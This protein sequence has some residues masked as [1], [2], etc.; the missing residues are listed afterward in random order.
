[1]KNDMHADTVILSKKLVAMDARGWDGPGYVAIKG[2][3]IVGVGH[4]DEMQAMVGPATVVTDVGDRVVMPGFVDP[5]IHLEA[6]SMI[7]H[8][9]VDVR[10]PICKSIKEMIQTLRAA[11]PTRLFDGWLLAQGN[12]FYDQKLEEKRYPTLAELDE[13]SRDIPVLVQAGGHITLL[14]SK[15]MEIAGIDRNYV[16]PEFSVAGKCVVVRD[17]NGDPTGQFQEME[18]VL[19]FPRVKGDLL[20]TAIRETTKKYLTEYGVTSIGEISETT[21]GLEAMSELQRDGEMPLRVATYLWVPG[22][23]TL[24]EACNWQQHIKPQSD[25]EWFNVEGVKIFTDG[26]FSSANAAMSIQYRHREQASMGEMAMSK[27]EIKHTYLSARASGLGLACHAVG[28][29]AQEAICE[30]VIETGVSPANARLRIEHGG[31]FLPDYARTTGMWKAAGA[32]PCPQPTFL[33]G[34]G[35]FFTYFFGK[36]DGARG[37]FP[38]KQMWDDGWTVSGSSDA[39]GGADPRASNPFFGIWCSVKR[40]TLYGEIIDPEQRVSVAQGLKM[41]T[42]AA[43]TILGHDDVKGSLEV[44]KFA[45]IIVLEKDPREE[46]MDELLKIKVDHVFVAGKLVHSRA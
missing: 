3:R 25:S 2:N 42:I 16:P 20:K 36:V 5:H 10:V 30:A 17:A 43:A 26:G 37:R 7:N 6:I 14:N 21:K 38:F 31:I 12:T 39:Y 23:M 15:A 40:E 32:K 27:E 46:E 8:T 34:L 45:D 33:F 29:K 1:M 11:I 22:T 4:Q 41:Y 44:G 19:P 13:I 18:A 28:D 9:Y 35:D 24:D